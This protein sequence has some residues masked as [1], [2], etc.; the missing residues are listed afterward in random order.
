MFC[1]KSYIKD[2]FYSTD[3]LYYMGRSVMYIQPN[4]NNITM[5]AAPKNPKK[6]SSWENLKSRIK[7][8][9]IDVIP[10]ATFKD[11]GKR[12]E[13]WKGIDELMSRPAENRLIMG[14]TALLTQPA[15]DY[16]NHRVDEETRRVSRNRTVAKIVAGTGVGILVRGFCYN[17]VSK[18]TDI[19]SESKL[20]K[21][22]IPKKYLEEAI[23]NPKFLKNYRSAL[24]MGVAILAMCVTNFVL[25]APITVFLTNKL[26][27]RNGKEAKN[28]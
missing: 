11:G 16:Y 27:A 3:V 1:N 20:S 14:A 24:S 12:V 13:N 7:Q 19:E 5:T 6:P 28:G 8:S 26:N 4:Y 25:D 17:V 18:M 2:N 23:A 21:S 22:L 15:I 9:I 10:S